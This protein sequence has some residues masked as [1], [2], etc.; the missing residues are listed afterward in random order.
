MN[1]QNDDESKKKLE[2]DIQNNARNFNV[3]LFINGLMVDDDGR[4]R[5]CH[6][7][8]DAFEFMV[9]WFRPDGLGRYV[10]NES[11]KIQIRHTRT[12][13]TTEFIDARELAEADYQS[14]SFEGY[15]LNGNWSYVSKH[16]FSVAEALM[17]KYLS[18]TSFTQRLEHSRGVGDLAFKIARKIE[19]E[20]PEHSLNP[21][22]VGFLG[23]V[24]DL[25]YF[26]GAEKHEVKTHEILTGVEGFPY[27]IARKTMH[28][29]LAEQYGEKERNVKQYLPVGIEGMII[30][31]ADMSVRTEQPIPIKDRAKEI[32]ERIRGIANMPDQLK[33]DIEENMHKALP[34]FER[35]ER[36]ILALAGVDSVNNF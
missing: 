32:I 36:I 5:L 27:D 34:R 28:G 16:R 13:L 8:K 15:I 11:K 30:T 1:Q 29:Q 22:L 31:Y 10:K 3:D 4:P 26:Y 24:H 23:Y 35:Y 17:K 33:Q 21:E 14:P 2:Q 18:A 12:N 9:G 20:N 6:S 7:P 19:K 25:G